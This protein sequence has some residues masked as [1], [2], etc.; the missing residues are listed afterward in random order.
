MVC[1]WGGVLVGWW[2]RSVSAEAKESV[3]GKE[4]RNSKWIRL[5]VYMHVLVKSVAITLYRTPSVA[6]MIVYGV[7]GVSCWSC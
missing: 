7:Y 5:R 1:W 6:F 2:S 4:K 3:R